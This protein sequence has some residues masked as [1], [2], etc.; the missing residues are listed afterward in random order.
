MTD[1]CRYA[2]VNNQIGIPL[3]LY[4]IPGNAV[5]GL[6][7]ALVARLGAH[8]QSCSD[9]GA[10]ATGTTTTPP[11]S[12]CTRHQNCSASHVVAVRGVPATVNLRADGIIDCFPNAFGRPAVSIFYFRKG[13]IEG[14]GT[15]GIG[16]GLTNLFV[17]R[18]TDLY[19]ST[20]AAMNMLGL[21]GGGFADV[22]CDRW[23]ARR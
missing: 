4:S 10:Q 9:Q 6:S 5:N 3:A 11:I 19:P 22:R 8:R 18:R 16:C 2:D 14:H 13:R 12:R 1:Y 17:S 23:K 7:P 20:K 21:P 15:A